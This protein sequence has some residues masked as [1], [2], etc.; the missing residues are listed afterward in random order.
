MLIAGSVP[1]TLRACGKKIGDG[2]KSK[3]VV[4]RSY[5]HSLLD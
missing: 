3:N 4:I 1:K 5:V 2:E